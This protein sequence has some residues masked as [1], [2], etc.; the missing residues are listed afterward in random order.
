[1]RA[2]GI[3]LAAI[4]VTGCAEP[5]GPTFDDPAQFVLPQPAMFVCDTWSPV[6]PGA[7]FGLFDVNFGPQGSGPSADQIRRVRWAGGQIVRRFNVPGLRAILP[8]ATAA[9]LDANSIIS[10]TDADA[11]V[12][13]EV[14]VGF[15]GELLIGSLILDN[16]GTILGALSLSR[17]I[18]ARVP[19]E[20]IPIIRQHSAVRYV[21]ASGFGCI[22]LPEQGA[23]RY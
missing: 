13:H 22:D 1:M 3:T 2:S 9:S 6:R 12:M 4:L 15:N 19:D 23:S 10:V 16:G 5:S 11:P 8:I 17:V 20:A 14:L 18:I 7:A 21:E